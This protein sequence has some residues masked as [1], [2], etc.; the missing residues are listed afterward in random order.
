MDGILIIDKPRGFTSHDVVDFIRKKFQIRKV[1]HA[2]TLDP[3]ATGVLV[4]LIGAF[5]KKSTRFSS[6]DKEYEACLRLGVATDT[7]DGQGRILKR[8]KVSRLN[9][10]QVEQVFGQFL[11]KIEQIP[12]MF[13]ALKIGGHKLYNLARKGIM[14]ERLPR[15]VYIYKIKVTQ[16]ALPHVYFTVKCSKGTYIRT[17]CVD[18]AKRLGFVGHMSQLRRI[19]S[20]HFGIAQALSWDKLTGFSPGQLCEILLTK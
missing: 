1:G 10:E 2:G 12:P 3:Q 4:V 20:G 7:Q 11:G 8:E 14:L 6:H 15:Q 9:L 13:S 16:F 5:T 18:L 19:S 17:L